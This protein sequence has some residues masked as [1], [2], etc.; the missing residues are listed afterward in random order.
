MRN[1]EKM[2]K[3]RQLLEQI[4]GPDLLRHG[5]FR[6]NEDEDFYIWESRKSFYSKVSISHDG[7]KVVIEGIKLYQE[8]GLGDPDMV[9]IV[10][11]AIKNTHSGHPLIFL[12]IFILVFL[13][14]GWLIA[15]LIVGA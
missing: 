7:T 13:S 10:R 2:A 15:D 12:A 9:E 3:E 6:T 11:E 1:C 4:I 5:L 8:V 14:G